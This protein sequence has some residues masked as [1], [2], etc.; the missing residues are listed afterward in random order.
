MRLGRLNHR[1]KIGGQRFSNAVGS[2]RD[3]IHVDGVGVVKPFQDAL[4]VVSEGASHPHQY[5][6]FRVG[7]V[8]QQPEAMRVIRLLELVLD[9]HLGIRSSLLGADVN[10]AGARQRYLCLHL[11]ESQVQLGT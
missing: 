3:G 8:S 7:G 11:F 4:V 5:V 2:H 10:P 6:G 1:A 9:H